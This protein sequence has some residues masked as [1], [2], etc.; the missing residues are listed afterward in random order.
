MELVGAGLGDHGHLTAAGAAVFGSVGVGLHAELLDAFD[1]GDGGSAIDAL[2]VGLDHGGDAVQLDVVDRFLTAIDG[3]ADS[4]GEEVAFRV[5]GGGGRDARHESE[6]RV[7]VA[8]VQRE[9]DDLPVFDDGAE[10][11]AGCF[12]QRA[13][14][15]DGH[16]FGDGADVE[17]DVYGG[18]LLG[19]Q[20]QRLHDVLAEA[21]GFGGNAVDTGRQFDDTIDAGGVGFGLVLLVA[22][23]V[24]DGDFGTYDGRAGAVGDDTGDECF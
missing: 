6:K 16:L 4:G 19:G 22:L 12:E 9:F 3:E 7:D 15:G 5:V 23:D 14:G 18:V 1:G 2:N 17:F 8:I 20:G 24:G 13:G 10:G 11:G 21:G